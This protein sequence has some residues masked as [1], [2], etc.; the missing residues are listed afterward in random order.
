MKN[1]TLGTLLAAA[2]SDEVT[3]P[4][5]ACLWGCPWRGPEDQLAVHAD[6]CQG[7]AWRCSHHA[8][9]VDHG[10]V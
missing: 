10:A 5:V 9:G 8:H 6:V 2:T 1:S 7:T 3:A 4:E